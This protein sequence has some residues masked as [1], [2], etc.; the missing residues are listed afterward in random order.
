M[1]FSGRVIAM[2]LSL[3]AAIAIA[4]KPNIP[5]LKRS[6][7]M[8]LSKNERQELERRCLGVSHPTCIELKS[9][10]FK[11]LMGLKFTTCE[12][13][14]AAKSIIDPYEGRIAKGVCNEQFGEYRDY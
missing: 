13:A 10:S 4:E 3:Y 7:I 5:D 2:S 6:E 14:A 8:E 1:L 9:K 11:M 12:A